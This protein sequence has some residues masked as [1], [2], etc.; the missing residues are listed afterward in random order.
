MI[1]PWNLLRNSA[2]H[3]HICSYSATYLLRSRVRRA[4]QR[5]PQLGSVIIIKKW[6]QCFYLGGCYRPDVSTN[7]QICNSSN[8]NRIMH[9]RPQSMQSLTQ[10]N[11]PQLFSNNSSSKSNKIICFLAQNCGV[12][13]TSY[14]QRKNNN[15]Y[16]H[17]QYSVMCALSTL[18]WPPLFA[19]GRKPLSY[20][21]RTMIQ[22]CTMCNNN[23]LL[24]T[25]H[26][27]YL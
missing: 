11:C 8:N 19:R 12:C 1:R 18:T 5:R 24:P 14:I 7:T 20:Y 10:V 23:C 9:H 27:V 16:Y 17:V 25:C 3:F 13:N 22:K 26:L 2:I 15:E 6:V 21:M 4:H